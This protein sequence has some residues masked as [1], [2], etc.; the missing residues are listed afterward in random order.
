M[1]I[2]ASGGRKKSGKFVA[3]EGTISVTTNVSGATIKITSG[4]SIVE[5]AVVTGTSFTTKGKL[6]PGKYE[7][8]VSKEGYDTYK[9]T[10]DLKGDYTINAILKES[11]KTGASAVVSNSLVEFKDTVL[12]NDNA[13]VTVTV[14]DS[15]G[16]V[17]PGKTVVFSINQDSQCTRKG[18]LEV[19]GQNVQTTDAN[20]CASFVVGL[21]KDHTAKSSTDSSKVASTKYTA[22][23]LGVTD[24]TNSEATGSIGFAALD[25]SK[26]YSN[27]E[28]VKANE[29]KLAQAKNASDK[30]GSIARTYSLNNESK[31]LDDR[32]VEYI[33]T[34]QVSSTGKDEHE[35]TFKTKPQIILPA[36]VDENAKA[37]EFVQVIPEA[38]RKSG[39]Y[40]TYA[41][42]SKI[43][44]LD[45]DASRLSYA[46]LMFKNITLSKY[47]KLSIKS[48]T[49]EKCE[50][51][52]YIDGS[53]KVIV[54]PHSQTDFGYQLPLNAG[55]KGIKVTIKSAGQVETDQNAGFEMDKIVGVY[56][57]ATATDAK[58]VDITSAKITWEN[59]EPT[60]SEWADLKADAVTSL[61]ISPKDGKAA[62]AT[63]DTFKYQLPV[64]PFTG[65]AVIKEMD[66]NGK[67]VGY[68]LAPTIKSNNTDNK[69]ANTNILDVDS[70]QAYEVTAEEA[71]THKV[72]SFKSDA[73][74]NNLKINS[75][76]VGSTNM[77]GTISLPSLGSEILD[78]SNKY[79][80][81][82]VQWNPI[83]NTDATSD[84]FVALAGQNIN[85]YAQLVDKNG[86]A[87]TQKDVNISYSCKNLPSSFNSETGITKIDKVAIVKN[88]KTDVNGRATLTLN[89][90][91]ADVITGLSATSSDYSVRLYIGDGKV[92][93]ADLYWVNADLGFQRDVNRKFDRTNN[94]EITVDAHKPTASTPW[95]YA[96]KTLGNTFTKADYDYPGV[97]EGYD[98]TIDGLKINTTID[99][100]N[101]GSYK[102]VGNGAVDTSSKLTGKDRI[103]NELDGTSVGK[104]V[105]FT[106]KADNEPTLTFK[107]VGEGSANLL[108]KMNLNI[109]WE[110]KGIKSAF[111]SPTGTT[112]ARNEVEESD[113][114]DNG[115]VELFVKVTDETGLNPIKGKTVTFTSNNTGIDTFSAN[116]AKTDANGIATVTLQTKSMSDTAI[117]SSII[118]AKVSDTDEVATTTINWTKY[119]KAFGLVNASP[120]E[121]NNKQIELTFNDDVQSASVKKEL[122]KIVDKEENPV[123]VVDAVA[124]G[125][126]VKLTLNKDLA[127]N[128]YTV[129]VKK[130]KMIDGVKYNLVSSKGI[131]IAY[132]TESDE[133]NV[134]LANAKFYSDMNGKFD[135]VVTEDGN[136][137]TNGIAIITL[138]NVVAPLADYDEQESDNGSAKFQKYFKI[139]VDGVIQKFEATGTPALGEVNVVGTGAVKIS[140][141]TYTI[142]LNQKAVDQKVTVYYLGC[143]KTFTVYAPTDVDGGTKLNTLVSDANTKI[144]KDAKDCDAAIIGTTDNTA[145]NI[146]TTASN[147]ST[148]IATEVEDPD[149]LI[150][151]DNSA[152]TIK[153]NDTEKE[154]RVKV[155]RFNVTYSMNFGQTVTKE[156]KLTVAAQGTDTCSIVNIDDDADTEYVVN[157][158]K[159]NE[160]KAI[161]D[162]FKDK[163]GNPVKSIAKTSLTGLAAKGTEITTEVSG[164]NKV[165]TGDDSIAIDVT[166]NNGASL[167]DPKTDTIK[168]TITKG[169]TKKTVTINVKANGTT[170]TVEVA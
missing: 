35:V 60:M 59:V 5:T 31:D 9:E 86:N 38:D 16:V 85:V 58:S 96:V 78:A 160:G 13:I 46:T 77:K 48:Y 163:N 23:V 44:V 143:S 11:V 42:L 111:V 109:S 151:V 64:F 53:E 28:K 140:A 156:Y 12:V 34:Q 61:G 62:T 19:K 50:D 104:D 27:T 71:L 94:N 26:V 54:G 76:K 52:D 91:Q 3:T 149:N 126:Y 65:D 49:T 6:A 157:S 33:A 137:T 20:G 18:L 141:N 168:L 105:T 41:D 84:A 45:E 125:K 40:F 66:S 47:S 148:V 100:D 74:G 119:D 30:V 102:V 56:K 155:A 144:A 63:T 17:V 107:C 138:N 161:K 152:H 139:V 170:Y 123:E 73:D 80:Y 129:T 165:L 108:A 87:V 51:K 88:T 8:E 120:V 14:K 117:K 24:N 55:V 159:A 93:T 90:A 81:T 89:S 135:C 32:D 67:V 7:V 106:A 118:T 142:K 99:S 134:P 110:A 83:P 95:Q 15:N 113:K 121:G 169:N 37:D 75:E 153:F 39:D 79:L 166:A 2:R 136:A 162:L 150:T 82:S 128:S 167:A 43:V 98:I 1:F 146:G 21:D 114:V 57:K 69:T 92:S 164:T 116:S 115:S 36:M 158:L 112:I 127:K 145:I 101:K 124:N 131:G 132:G 70:V 10:I 22:K 130:D 68:Y 97:L 25:L 133:T 154:N 72:G 103:I 29:G 4:G 147:G 122:F